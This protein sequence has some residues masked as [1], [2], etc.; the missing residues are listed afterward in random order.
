MSGTSQYRQ[1]SFL[2]GAAGQAILPAF[3]SLSERPHIPGALGSCPFDNEELLIV[4][5]S[6]TDNDTSPTTSNV[7]DRDETDVPDRT[8]R[9]PVWIDPVV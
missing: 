7:R 3:V 1:T 6:I 2:L 4:G 9:W 5:N 8:R